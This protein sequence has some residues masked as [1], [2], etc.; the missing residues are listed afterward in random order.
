MPKSN[1]QITITISG[2][3]CTGKTTLAHEIISM[4]NDVGIDTVA[5]KSVEF[6]SRFHNDK[7]ESMRQAGLR[8]IVREVQ[9]NKFAK[10][11]NTK[12]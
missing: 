8:V 5:D 10:E 6:D 1:P 7:I 3:V 12:S 11:N 4:L 9:T 2:N